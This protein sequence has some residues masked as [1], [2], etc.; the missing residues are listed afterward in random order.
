MKFKKPKSKFIRKRT[1]FKY[2]R[3]HLLPFIVDQVLQPQLTP[4]FQKFIKGEFK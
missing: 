2:F 1:Y 4:T 3:K